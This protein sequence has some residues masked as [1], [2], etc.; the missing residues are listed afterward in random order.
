MLF[1]LGYCYR[2]GI[3]TEKGGVKTFE[4]Y[5]K[6]AEK[7]QID[8]IYQLGCC[9]ENGIGSEKNELKHLNYMKKQL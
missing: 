3:E 4:L 8:S 7:G 6:A 5:K 2:H 9:Y 1:Q